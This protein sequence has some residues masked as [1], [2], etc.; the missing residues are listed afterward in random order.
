MVIDVAA[1]THIG[2]LRD[3]NEDSYFV[4]A[5][6]G[7]FI[8]CD[9]MG[10]HLAGEVASQKAI[11]FVVDFLRKERAQRTLPERGEC[12]FAE[13][14]S[15]L[16]VA[17]IE[18]CCDRLLELADSRSDFYGMATTLTMLLI[19]EEVAFV[20]HLGDCRLYLKHGGVARQLTNDHTL[21]EEFVDANPDWINS[22]V[23]PF[24]LERF[25]HIVTKCVGRERSFSVDS[26]SF[27]LCDADV[28]LLC[29]D[30]LSNYF[31]DEE[32]VF[33]LLDR[34]DSRSTVN[35]LVEFAN[36]NG[37]KDNITAIVLAVL[38]SNRF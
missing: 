29:S 3:K 15:S 27:V 2:C 38:Q 35:S 7:L 32:F 16:V 9:G 23:D 13:A 10:G 20:G 5:E 34:T 21:Y 31:P 30:G 14:W 11:E 12:G 36:S 28:L 25:R 4:D 22:K 24:E 26:F 19:V 18:D 8:V 6:S 1:K 17:A 33:R 37:G